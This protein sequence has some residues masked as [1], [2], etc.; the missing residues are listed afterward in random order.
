MYSSMSLKLSNAI[1]FDEL[2]RKCKALSN[3]KL[4]MFYVKNI[5]KKNSTF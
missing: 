2:L 4:Q 3:F 5:S 1:Y